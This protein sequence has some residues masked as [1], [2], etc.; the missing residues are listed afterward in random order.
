MNFA[1]SHVFRYDHSDEECVSDD[2]YERGMTLSDSDDS[3]NDDAVY[4]RV[5]GK[6]Q[7]SPA[8]STTPPVK[9]RKGIFGKLFRSSKG[10]TSS[11]TYDNATTDSVGND[12]V[13]NDPMYDNPTPS[14]AAVAV[15]DN[16]PKKYK[17]K[18]T[19]HWRSASSNSEEKPTKEYAKKYRRADTNVVQVKF[20]TLVKPSNMH[21][22]DATY[23]S[24]GALLS[25]IS[26]LNNR[27]NSDE[28]EWK[29]EFCNKA[30]IVDIMDEEIPL[31]NDV[32]YM[33]QPAPATRGS[34]LSGTDES[35][36]VFCVDTSGS[37]CITTE[38]PGRFNLRGTERRR[39]DRMQ[40]FNEMREDQHLPGER[41]NVTYVSRLQGVQAAVGHQLDDMMKEFPTRRAALVTFDSE[42]CVIGDGTNEPVTIAGDKLSNKEE[43][44][45]IGAE[46]PLPQPIKDSKHILSDK[47]YQLEEGGA[48]AL[49]PGLLLAVSM[50]GQCP[51]SKVIICT[52]GK[53]NV[54]LGSLQANSETDEL[55]ETAQLFYGEVA[56]HALLKGVSV[57]VISIKGTDCKMVELGNVSDQT[58]GQVNIVDPLK[59]TEEFGNI[60]AD[61]IIAT[62]VTAT[63]LLHRGLYFRNE[64]S[65]Q[66]KTVRQVGNVTRDTEITFEYGVRSKPQSNQPA[67]TVAEEESMETD[68]ATQEGATAAPSNSNQSAVLDDDLTELPFQ[69]QINYTDTNGAQAL[70]VLSMVKP[71]TK[72]RNV[73]EKNMDL[74][75]LGT[76][77]AQMSARLA[78]E[79]EY[80]RSRLHSMMHQRLMSRATKK[81]K[82]S[83]GIYKAWF[84]HV[85]PMEEHINRAQTSERTA[86]GRSYSDDEG[87]DEIHEEADCADMVAPPSKGNSAPPRSKKKAL[88]AMK[89]KS[90]RGECSD[91]MATVI[92][93]NKQISANKMMSSKD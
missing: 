48:T 27:E 11:A 81:D 46:A 32:T 33:I 7:S 82:S 64:A 23:C 18:P 22:G 71:V 92:Y 41:R 85:A 89:S 67:A 34:G 5:L 74:K 59:L 80:S 54:G 77:A 75:L 55:L 49:G 44:I 4:T 88:L 68:Q 93:Q 70:R 38:V 35:L 86:Y 57:S 69:L 2:E 24:C 76:N 84:S 91:S 65:K 13:P 40:S 78:T 79:G 12:A 6:A 29:C 58:G 73:A 3:D 83:R 20:D 15:Y 72:D 42:V 53:A 17:R 51:G 25:H 60:L 14:D 8:T 37:M 26:K 39:L 10:A 66:S 19:N 45:K 31:T 16:P 87:P 62:N 63:L 21:T 9:S 43:L 50:A 90:R 30:N 36:V 47:I 56:Q 61:Q 1:S 52:D 28:K